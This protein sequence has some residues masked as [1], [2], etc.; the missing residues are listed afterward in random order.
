MCTNSSSKHNPCANINLLLPCLTFLFLLFTQIQIPFLMWV[1]IL[2]ST[3][4]ATQILQPFQQLEQN[5]NKAFTTK[6]LQCLLLATVLIYVPHLDNTTQTVQLV[7]LLHQKDLGLMPKC[8]N[9]HKNKLN[10]SEIGI[11][12]ILFD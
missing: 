5:Q 3:H 8:P 11:A 7:L 9:F 6:L 1:I 12:A 2:I 4:N 10:I